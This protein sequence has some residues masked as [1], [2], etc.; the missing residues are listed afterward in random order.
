MT[1]YGKT[2]YTRKEKKLET[3]EVDTGHRVN[4]QR[5]GTGYQGKTGGEDEER[6]PGYRKEGGPERK[7]WVDS[8]LER[9]LYIEGEVSLILRSFQGEGKNSFLFSL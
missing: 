4:K 8:F 2:P 5:P 1:S 7:K 9:I 3:V 6:D